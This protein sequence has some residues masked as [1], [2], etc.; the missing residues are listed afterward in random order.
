MNIY[1]SQLDWLLTQKARY[2]EALRVT[3]PSIETAR[4]FAGSMHGH[5]KY[6]NRPYLFHLDDVALV[7]DFVSRT[8]NADLL[9]AG[10]LHDTVEDTGVTEEILKSVF[11]DAIA[12]NV[13]F[14]TKTEGDSRKQTIAKLCAKIEKLNCQNVVQVDGLILKISDRIAN[15][16][17]SA[18][19]DSSKAKSLYDVYLSENKKLITSIEL[20]LN[21]SFVLEDQRDSVAN[22]LSLLKGFS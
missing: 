18:T 20:V 3:Y 19:D 15:L 10:Y 2:L 8:F 13:M 16:L 17:R 7:L 14:A 4:E 21:E 1:P 11:G 9:K 6:G 22:C 5:A 12:S